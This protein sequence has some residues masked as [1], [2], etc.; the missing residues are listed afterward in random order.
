MIESRDLGRLLAQEG[1]SRRTL[2]RQILVHLIFLKL[3]A[4]I[5][6]D[7]GMKILGFLK[8]SLRKINLPCSLFYFVGLSW[9]SK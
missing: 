9:A 2:L 5:Y 4:R 1:P 3:L 8:R 6:G 7:F